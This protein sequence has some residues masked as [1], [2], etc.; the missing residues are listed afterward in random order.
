MQIHVIILIY[1]LSFFSLSGLNKLQNRFVSTC[2][3]TY[4]SAS[5]V[6]GTKSPCSE[7]PSPIPLALGRLSWQK[8]NKVYNMPLFLLP[9]EFAARDMILQLFGNSFS[10]LFDMYSSS[11]RHTF[12]W[13]RRL[14]RLWHHR[15]R[16]WLSCGLLKARHCVAQGRVRFSQ[17]P[18]H[19]VAWKRW[20]SFHTIW[21]VLGIS[22][23][24]FYN[25]YTRY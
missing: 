11:I 9:R 22:D 20:Q 24:K 1:T 4:G 13:H 21:G 18:L 12:K 23:E 2:V 8:V 14:F 7:C 25:I 10:T 6:A 5:R 15:T 19:L 17:G 3:V 16:V